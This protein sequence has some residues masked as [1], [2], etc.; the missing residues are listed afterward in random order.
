MRKR[1]ARRRERDALRRDDQD[2]ELQAR[3]AAEDRP[4][5]SR[6]SG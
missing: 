3:M 2:L 6:L 1:R 5:V 4:S